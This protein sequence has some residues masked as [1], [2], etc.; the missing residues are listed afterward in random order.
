MT[1]TFREDIDDESTDIYDIACTRLAARTDCS[2]CIVI[3]LVD[4][5]LVDV[6]VVVDVYDVELKD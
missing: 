3:V 1:G 5:K 2:C 4:V 6:M